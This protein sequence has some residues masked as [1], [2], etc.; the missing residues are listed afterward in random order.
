VDEETL[1]M[2]LEVFQNTNS[3]LQ[4][5]LQLVHDMGQKID[6]RWAAISV[7]LRCPIS[8]T[9]RSAGFVYIRSLRLIV[10]LVYG[11]PR[12]LVKVA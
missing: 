9:I 5:C 4:E 3:M 1:Q 11:L 6:D 7:I 12:Q 10:H 2:M 8:S